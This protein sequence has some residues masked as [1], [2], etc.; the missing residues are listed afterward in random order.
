MTAAFATV[1][2]AAGS[3]WQ[4]VQWPGAEA[5][6]GN[7]WLYDC[8]QY[9]TLQALANNL[10]GQ[11]MDQASAMAAV[12]A[13][14][15][16]AE[17]QAAQE[18]QMVTLASQQQQLSQSA[19]SNPSSTTTASGSVPGIESNTGGMPGLSSGTA[20][21]ADSIVQPSSMGVSMGSQNVGVGAPGSG[22][23]GSSGSGASLMSAS[24]LGHRRLKQLGAPVGAGSNA[25]ASS[26]A[27][28][29]TTQ[30]GA[31]CQKPIQGVVTGTNTGVFVIPNFKGVASLMTRGNDTMMIQLGG[32][33][34]QCVAGYRLMGGK[35]LDVGR[36]KEEV[37]KQQEANKKSGAGGATA[38]W[39]LALLLAPLALWM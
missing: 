12:A 9:M 23:M 20:G 36:S 27:A 6:Q 2:C 17:A 22:G 26:S 18:A 10:N 37:Q 25:L 28:L 19:A 3:T 14:K 39:V 24:S 33:G 38:G 11:A 32:Q 15:A 31:A 30:L 5:C 8:A 35:I 16:A 1:P 4:M 29:P 7:T 34:S 13:A 21:G